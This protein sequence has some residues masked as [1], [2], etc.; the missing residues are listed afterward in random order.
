MS[1]VPLFD[2]AQEGSP[3]PFKLKQELG[4]VLLIPDNELA[5]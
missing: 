4:E 1:E 2:R 3:L 5:V